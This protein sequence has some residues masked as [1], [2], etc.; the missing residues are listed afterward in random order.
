MKLNTEK[1]GMYAEADEG[2]QRGGLYLINLKRAVM[3]LSEE[4]DFES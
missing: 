4:K 2:G 1:Q 3:E